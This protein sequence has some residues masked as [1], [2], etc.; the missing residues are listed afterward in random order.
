M[1][2]ALV[3]REISDL[4]VD[5]SK[6]DANELRAKEKLIHNTEHNIYEKF[7]NYTDRSNHSQTIVAAFVEVRMSSLRLTLSYRRS[8]MAEPESRDAERYQ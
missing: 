4:I 7:L 1:T 5:L 2:F 3:N 6:L 8:K